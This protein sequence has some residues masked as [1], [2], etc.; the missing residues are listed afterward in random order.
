MVDLQYLDP[1]K[2]PVFLPDHCF[3]QEWIRTVNLTGAGSGY[4]GG[5]QTVDVTTNPFQLHKQQRFRTSGGLKAFTVTARG[6][7]TV[8][9]Q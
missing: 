6:G 7:Y 9:Q 5:Q 1:L 8:F 2:H 3:T 4:L